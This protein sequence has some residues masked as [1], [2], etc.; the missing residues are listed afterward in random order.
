MGLFA[1]DPISIE[2]SG[3]GT[4]KSEHT[5]SITLILCDLGTKRPLKYAPPGRIECL[6]EYRTV[7]LSHFS[8][9]NSTACY[10][11]DTSAHKHYQRAGV[12]Q[13]ICLCPLHNPF[14]GPSPPQVTQPRSR[15]H[16]PRYYPREVEYAH[17]RRGAIYES[18]CPPAKLLG[19]G[20]GDGEE[21]VPARVD[22]ARTL[23]GSP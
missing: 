22:Q 11:W 20:S 8:W 17:L 12:F 13:M 19:G 6:Y 7:S 21:G 1:T 9:D 2:V 5:L 18:G 15:I 23:R 3:L 10:R 4:T 16:W 14:S